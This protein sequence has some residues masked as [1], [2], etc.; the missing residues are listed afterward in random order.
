MKKRDK[1]LLIL[2]IIITCI[3][4]FSSIVYNTSPVLIN[5]NRKTDFLISFSGVFSILTFIIPI[6]FFIGKILF[7]ITKK[8]NKNTLKN[9]FLYLFISFLIFLMLDG[10]ANLILR[11]ASVVSRETTDNNTIENYIILKNPVDKK[12]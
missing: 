2:L 7:N 10:I 3:V 6:C 4:Q 8:N 9:I 12:G 11:W 1:Y 5:N